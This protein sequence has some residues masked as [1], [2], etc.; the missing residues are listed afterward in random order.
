MILTIK[1][2][3]FTIIWLVIMCY[4]LFSPASNLPKS[5]FLNIPHLDKFIHSILFGVLVFFNFHENDSINKLSRK[6][7]IIIIFS[8]FVFAAI[9]ELI[10]NAY[11][12]GRA[13]S[14]VDFYADISGCFLGV[15]CYY[16]VWKNFL[17]KKLFKIS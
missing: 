14:I 8:A 2:Y 12:S 1:T 9:S 6:L 10:Q 3:R 17:Q 11:I 4:V 16:F 13:G 7:I 5:S 15:I